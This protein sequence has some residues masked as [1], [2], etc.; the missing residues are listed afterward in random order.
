MSGKASGAKGNPAATRMGNAKLKARRASSWARGQRRKAARIEANLALHYAKV[1]N[2][3]LGARE[4][5]RLI[6]GVRKG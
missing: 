6:A 1:Q 2:N 3:G 4:M 5:R